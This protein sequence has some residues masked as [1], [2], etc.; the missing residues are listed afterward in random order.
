MSQERR[1]GGPSF[2]TQDSRALP[3][4]IVP[5]CVGHVLSVAGADGKPLRILIR[6]SQPE[7]EQLVL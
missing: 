4:N 5:A 2:A 3:G 6:A 7:V 1:V